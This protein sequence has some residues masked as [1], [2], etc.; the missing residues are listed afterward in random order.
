MAQKINTKTITSANSI[1]QIRCPSNPLH[2]G[3]HQI[4][5]AQAD[6]MWSFD[7][8]TKAETRIG[9]DNFLSGGYTPFKTVMQLFLEANSDSFTWMD[10]LLS[11][12]DA[13]SE[14]APVEI[15]LTIPSVGL[16][17]SGEG[18]ITS[19]S[20]GV[21]GGRLLDGVSYSVDLKLQREDI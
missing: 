20:G 9:V 2:S 12:F 6:N 3:W 19:G 4:Q 11:M 18:F 17:Y 5:G 10:R 1:L 15:S 14:T 13:D 16:R 21:T 8:P 7:N